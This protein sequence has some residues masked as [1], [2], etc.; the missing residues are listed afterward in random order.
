MDLNPSRESHKSQ[1]NIPN[2]VL[3]T[4]LK[5]KKKKKVHEKNWKKKNE[6]TEFLK[7][8]GYKKKKWAEVDAQDCA[9]KMCTVISLKAL[10]SQS[11]SAVLLSLS[12]ELHRQ[13]SSF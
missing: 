3:N 1:A 2:V 11:F 8:I 9:G 12:N 5:K 4:G 10:G 6:K 7:R 13:I